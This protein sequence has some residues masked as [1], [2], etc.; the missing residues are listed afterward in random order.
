MIYRKKWSDSWLV[1]RLSN[2]SNKLDQLFMVMKNSVVYPT[3]I[4]CDVHSRVNGQTRRFDAR[5]FVIVF[6]I[7][8]ISRCFNSCMQRGIKIDVKIEIDIRAKQIHI[9]VKTGRP[10][11]PSRFFD[12]ILYPKHSGGAEGCAV[13]PFLRAPTLF[14]QIGGPQPKFVPS[15][16]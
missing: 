5:S 6:L 8:A 1:F 10:P 15:N 7:I 3:I 9:K 4:Y 13:V 11:L 16:C 14:L 12:F 2:H